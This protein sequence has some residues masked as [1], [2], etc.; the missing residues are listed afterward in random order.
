M[1]EDIVDDGVEGKSRPSS[2]LRPQTAVLRGQWER[3]ACLDKVMPRRFLVYPKKLD[4][5]QPPSRPDVS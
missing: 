4:I 5:S 2:E 1:A 3:C